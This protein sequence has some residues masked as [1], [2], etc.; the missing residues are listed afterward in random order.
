MFQQIYEKS[1]LTFYL[2]WKVKSLFLKIHALEKVKHELK[3]KSEI[4][5][6]ERCHKRLCISIS[7]DV[8][9]FFWVKI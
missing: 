1:K 7:Y 6:L 9:L 8:V 5:H 3:V 4:T 2:K